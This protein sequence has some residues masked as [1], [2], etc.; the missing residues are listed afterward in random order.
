M[1]SKRQ[2]NKSELICAYCGKEFKYES[3]RKRHEQSHSPQFEC[4][5]CAK[6][7]SFLSAVRRHEKQHE[8]TGSVSCNECNRKFRD[9]TLLERHI[10][11][12]HKGTFTCTKCDTAFSSELAL[13]AHSKTH[14]PKSERQYRCSFSG[15]TKTFNFTHHLKHHEL[16]HT[17]TK[18]HHCSVCGKGFIQLHHLKSH[19]KK[20]GP[21]NW[22]TCGIAECKK[23][24]P[25]EY[26]LKRHIATHNKIKL[27]DIDESSSERKSS[28]DVTELIESDTVTSSTCDQVSLQEFPHTDYLKECGVEKEVIN[29]ENNSKAKDNQLKNSEAVRIDFEDDISTCKSF[30]GGCIMGADANGN[31]KCLCAQISKHTINYELS[32][33]EN[34]PIQLENTPKKTVENVKDDVCG[35]CECSNNK[36]WCATSLNQNFSV[37]DVNKD[38]PKIEYKHDGTIRI[39]DTFDI[40]IPSGKAKEDLDMVPYNSCKAVLGKC[41][42]GG[43]GTI[44]EGCLCARM[45]MDDQ[46]MIAQEIDELTPC[47]K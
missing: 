28:C 9:E 43:N 45:A 14:R 27:D 34:T 15:C 30:V 47:P 10:K 5:V 12:A 19:L 23:T 44:D 37:S 11:Y 20:H 40:D 33:N 46:Q 6:K 1:K 29:T 4:K 8:R 21:E 35:D 18:Q 42:V 25:T 22:L 31:D 38:L 17:N 39:T 26:A 24:F 3:E 41:I 2:Q 32:P 13:R 16:T 7:F 36:N